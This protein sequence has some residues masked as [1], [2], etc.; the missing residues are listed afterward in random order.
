[1]K[2]FIFW[3]VVV[4]A[5]WAVIM[6]LLYL[7]VVYHV[8]VEHDIAK[9]FALKKAGYEV[10]VLTGAMLPVQC[11]AG[12][13]LGRKGQWVCAN[14][15]WGSGIGEIENKDTWGKHV[16]LN[17]CAYFRAH[18]RLLELTEFSSISNWKAFKIGLAA[19]E[20]V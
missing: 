16:G 20:T 2:K 19:C 12:A 17:P 14:Y 15:Y 10:P 3:V 13:G 5:A 11:G 4:L 6:N 8:P 18:L 9:S 7:A 1:M